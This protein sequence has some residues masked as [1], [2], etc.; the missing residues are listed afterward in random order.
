[1]ARAGGKG[2]MGDRV[3]RVRGGGGRDGERGWCIYGRR[4]RG[5]VVTLAGKMALLSVA[6]GGWAIALGVGRAAGRRGGRPRG[7][8]SAACRGTATLE[9]W[10]SLRRCGCG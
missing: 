4:W 10:R 3:V 8:I 9:R 5:G 1:M 7:L 6:L 2:T